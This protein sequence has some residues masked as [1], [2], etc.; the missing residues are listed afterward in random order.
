[1]ELVTESK[2]LNKSCCGSSGACAEM[3][4]TLNTD[5]M[6]D[7]IGLEM[8]SHTHKHITRPLFPFDLT[9]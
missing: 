2:T 9:S 3:R 4:W 6:D 8:F 5:R 7:A 1:M